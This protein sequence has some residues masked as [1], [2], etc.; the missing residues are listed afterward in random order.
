M[1]FINRGRLEIWLES[2]KLSSLLTSLYG[3]SNNCSS[4]FCLVIIIMGIIIINFIIIYYASTAQT[5]AWVSDPEVEL[6]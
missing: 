4:L 1:G 3:S 2:K 5:N 6:H